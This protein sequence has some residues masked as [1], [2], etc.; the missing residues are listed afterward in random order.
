M[1][2]AYPH[3]D[4]QATV[5]VAPARTGARVA[6]IDV[7][8]DLTQAEPVWRQ[9]LD[10]GALATPYQQF[11]WI[12]LWQKHVGAA[13]GMVP[14]LIVGY[15]SAGAPM[16][17]LPLARQRRGLLT[18][19]RFFGGKHSNF[20]MGIWRCDVVGTITPADLHDVLARL[21]GYGIDFLA[22]SYQPETWEGL[23]NPLALLPHQP[24][25]DNSYCLTLDAPGPDIIARR[26]NPDTRR[27]LRRKERHLAD[28]PGY[29]YARATTAT[30]V[31]RY[32]N[33][34]FKQKSARLAARGIS[35]AFAEPGLDAFLREACHFGLA[36][37]EPLI[38]IHAL[39]SE[40]EVL[41]LFSG[42]HDS[43]YFTTMFNSYTL[44][45]HAR[46]SPGLTLLI[47]LVMDC[48]ARGFRTFSLGPGAS[49]YKAALCDGVEPLFDSFLP[50]SRRGALHAAASRQIYRL[51]RRVKNSPALWNLIQTA[52]RKLA[53][54]G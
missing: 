40:G 6:R 46:M 18:V 16:F 26:F 8:S 20:N 11:D 25:P 22:L 14:F 21:A 35:N 28:L 34:F 4:P 39:D 54:R 31:D 50:L 12:A 37:G 2:I 17:L 43:R 41:A 3:R 24:S 49:D 30:D 5:A 9:L 48:A 47:H 15:D 44:G 45:E 27:K 53:R 7:F 51:R 33:A 1:N 10:E 52:R 36:R 32:L 29:R 42:I 38:E 19:A 23:P 13:S